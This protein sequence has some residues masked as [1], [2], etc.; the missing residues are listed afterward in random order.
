MPTNCTAH[1]SARPRNLGAFGP[2]ARRDGNLARSSFLGPRT[3]RKRHD[4]RD[5]V[6]PER[7]RVATTGRPRSST[8]PSR[9]MST[10]ECRNRPGWNR[11]TEPPC[12]ESLVLLLHHKGRYD[13]LGVDESLEGGSE[14]ERSQDSPDQSSETS[15][16]MSTAAALAAR[17]D[18]VI[19]KFAAQA[20]LELRVETRETLRAELLE[21]ARTHAARTV[22]ETA[23]AR[24]AAKRPKS[25]GRW[26]RQPQVR[27]P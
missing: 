27:R 10:A 22:L 16:A 4:L 7:Y 6:A 24:Y 19:A 9:M 15:P 2:T 20:S 11:K 12:P 25:R 17:V 13:T 8:I 21:L 3:R 14:M 5:P 1:A 23:T 26:S 18:E